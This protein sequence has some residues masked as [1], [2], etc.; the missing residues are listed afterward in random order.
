MGWAMN[1]KIETHTDPTFVRID[2]AGT[3]TVAECERMVA[4]VL[5]R[6]FWHS[7]TPLLINCLKVDVR[8]LRYDDV[9]RSGLILRKHRDEFGHCR[10][11]IISRPG[12]GYG[13]S[14]QFKA[15]TEVKTDIDVEVFLD[16]DSAVEW[17]TEVPDKLHSKNGFYHDN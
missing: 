15:L 1:W 17:L 4:D 6:D 8:S 9:D 12:L 13:V 14:R 10:M 3:A 5:S 11:A 7:D 2:A 16:E